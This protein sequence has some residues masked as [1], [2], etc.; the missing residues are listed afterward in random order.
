[1]PALHRAGWVLFLLSSVAFLAAGVRDGD[2]VVIVGSVL[3][4]VACVLFLVRSDGSS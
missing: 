1:M 3:F 4:A 2:V